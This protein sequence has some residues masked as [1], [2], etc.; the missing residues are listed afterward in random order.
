MGYVGLPLAVEFAKS[1]YCVTGIDIDDDKIKKLNDGVSYIQDVSSKDLKELVMK[2][3]ITGT[4]VM[5]LLLKKGALLSYHDP[6]IPTF[7][8][9]GQKF[10]SRSIGNE[11][12][13]GHDC[14]VIVTDHASIN[15]RQVV[16]ESQLI[17]DTRNTLKG[18]QESHIIRL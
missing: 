14:V 18:F 17:V 7:V 3:K 9:G 15:Y 6:F 5:T 4:N 2:N 1:G 13:R 8:L 10:I 12:L 16:K 11:S